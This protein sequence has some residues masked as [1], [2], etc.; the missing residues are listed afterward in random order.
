M[1][2]TEDVLQTFRE[3]YQGLV[4]VTND[5]MDNL[6]TWIWN[7]SLQKVFPATTRI[8]MDLRSGNLYFNPCYFVASLLGSIAEDIMSFHLNYEH[9]VTL[10]PENGICTSLLNTEMDFLL[11]GFDVVRRLILQ[12]E[13]DLTN[14]NPME[15]RR[16]LVKNLDSDSPKIS[17]FGSSVSF[18]LW[19]ITLYT[20]DEM[21]DRKELLET[22]EKWLEFDLGKKF[23]A[24][25]L[26]MF[27]DASP[28]K[29]TNHQMGELQ[30][31]FPYLEEKIDFLSKISHY[32]ETAYSYLEF[33]DGY[34][35]FKTM[36]DN[37]TGYS[38][39]FNLGYGTI[40]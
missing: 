24:E 25:D 9:A 23:T 38:F 4:R 8:F 22:V 1:K 30:V 26:S 20:I 32:A 3:E 35:S 5:E 17:K 12:F 39:K 36:L 27:K 15:L 34:G 19:Y 7:P 29:K 40:Y 18:S 14:L 28:C 37:W 11:D 21:I 31:D 33:L 2:S 6:I 10:E 13:Y 16:H